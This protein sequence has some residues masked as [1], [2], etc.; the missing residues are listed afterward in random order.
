MQ[1]LVS[2]LVYTS[3]KR[4]RSGKIARSE[5][6]LKNESE[7]SVRTTPWIELLKRQNRG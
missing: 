4:Y 1:G 2:W 3:R 5:V 7:E 6:T